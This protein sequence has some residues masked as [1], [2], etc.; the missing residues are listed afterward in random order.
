MVRRVMLKPLQSVTKV[1]PTS[2]TIDAMVT[3]CNK[4]AEGTQTSLFAVFPCTD[5]AGKRLFAGGRHRGSLRD[6]PL[7][8]DAGDDLASVEASIFDKDFGSVLSS[9]HDACDVDAA[10]IAFEGFRLALRAARFG[11]EVNALA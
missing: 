8:G 9:Q 1:S 5:S 7:S 3:H 11:V 4:V 6:F 2:L 10:D